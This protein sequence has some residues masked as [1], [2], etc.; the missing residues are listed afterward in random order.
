MISITLTGFHT[1]SIGHSIKESTWM[2]RAYIQL[3]KLIF[4]N[5]MVSDTNWSN[6]DEMK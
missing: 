6:L 3:I 2:L 5:L 4:I 1:N